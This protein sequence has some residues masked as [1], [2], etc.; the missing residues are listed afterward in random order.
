MKIFGEILYSFNPTQG[1]GLIQPPY[2][3]FFLVK[4]SKKICLTIPL[5]RIPKILLANRKSQKK[6]VFLVGEGW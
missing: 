2:L 6:Y 4:Y 5:V 3:G 1:G